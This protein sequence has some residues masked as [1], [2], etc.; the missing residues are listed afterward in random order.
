MTPILSLVAESAPP[1]L[2]ERRAFQRRHA[3][4]LARFRATNR[5]FSPGVRARL[6][7]I[8]QGGVGVL[9]SEPF[10][11][12]TTVE[13]ELEPTAGSYRLIR[14]AEI[15]WMKIKADGQYRLGSCFEKR[16]TFAEMQRF[17]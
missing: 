4:G 9:A 8:S 11:V 17:V 6:Q 7:D 16:L 3:R 1:K 15:R 2:L 10:D 14:L 13:L 5:P 12:G